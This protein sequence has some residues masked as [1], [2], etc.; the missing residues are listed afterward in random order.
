MS[1]LTQTGDTVVLVVA[2]VSNTGA[3]NY[4]Y[5]ASEAPAG[6]PDGDI[7]A[8]PLRLAASPNPSRGAVAFR[9][10][11][12]G[13]AQG[14]ARIELFD[15]LGRLVRTLT[16]PAENGAI[17]LAWDG[18][19]TDGRAATPGI[20]YARATAGSRVTGTRLVRLP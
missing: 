13:P 8:M 17:A 4:I 1:G 18:R 10:D 12:S 5:R 7:A 14:A 16:A 9:L 19:A 15:A 3:G 6:V 20:Y 2:A 11:W